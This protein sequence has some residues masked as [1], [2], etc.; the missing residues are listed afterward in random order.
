LS[1]VTVHGDG[2]IRAAALT[3][4]VGK[5]DNLHAVFVS[6]SIVECP[7]PVNISGNIS[8]SVVG[9]VGSATLFVHSN[10][11]QLVGSNASAE[12]SLQFQPDSLQPISGH[13]VGGNIVTIHGSF[14]NH[15]ASVGR[16]QC[17]FG[18]SA[19]GIVNASSI[20]SAGSGAASFVCVSPASVAGAVSVFL[21]LG[22]DDSAFVDTEFVF[23]YVDSSVTALDPSAGPMFGGNFV[24]VLGTGFSPRS[25][26]ACQ[27]GNLP[28]VR[29]LWQH[30][31]SVVCVAPPAVSSGNISVGL[32][33]SPRAVRY[34]YVVPVQ[35]SVRRS[36]D[37]VMRVVPSVLGVSGGNVLT[38]VG[39]AARTTA[40]SVSLMIGVAG[41]N[42]SF[43]CDTVRV[44][45]DSVVILSPSVP[46][47][48][49]ECV[50]WV[51]VD[52][53][54]SSG[55]RVSVHRDWW[56]HG[57]HAAT[58]YGASAAVFNVVGTQLR[59]ACGSGRF[60]AM[61]GFRVA[62]GC[63]A[64][65]NE[66]A[67]CTLNSSVSQSFSGAVRIS[68]DHTGWMDTSLVMRI[69]GSP[70]Q[71]I[72]SGTSMSPIAN[73]QNAAPMFIAVNSVANV[74][75]NTSG[76]TANVGMAT[77]DVCGRVEQSA[78]SQR[79]CV[80]KFDACVASARGLRSMRLMSVVLNESGADSSLLE[81][82]PVAAP[83]LGFTVV[84]SVD[85]KLATPFISSGV[86]STV[87]VVTGDVL[88]ADDVVACVIRH[89]AL[90]D[91]SEVVV[92]AVVGDGR[93]ECGVTPL[94]HGDVGVWLRL[95]TTLSEVRWEV[96]V[97]FG[98]CCNV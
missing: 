9:S 62:A 95:E 64:G 15:A 48:G 37:V 80:L 93:V 43:P 90:R 53:D 54:T 81:F 82:G 23:T 5:A 38:V 97:S 69:V 17:R 7:L 44:S 32:T 73:A 70:L 35:S 3:C 86:S 68:C 77:F 60:F 40:V 26:L 55:V 56:V 12:L 57:L 4:R 45:N 84:P 30:A 63:V 71:L 59:L 13:I 28:E 49:A 33:G 50:A 36:D 8:V 31:G 72:W 58:V 66:F 61:V 19:S 6:P 18:A 27:F 46:C 92:D 24:T 75:I 42:A 39:Q 83:S 41:V 88:H 98:S 74:E 16:I 47:S 89:G 22:S 29:A 78:C 85:F 10:L 87:V 11:R 52:G 51:V 20:V 91:D 14:L 96:A 25:D 21:R 1:V 94:M 34:E 67:V 79:G 65:S 76:M 2:F